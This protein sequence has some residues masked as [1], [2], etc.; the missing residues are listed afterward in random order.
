MLT[1]YYATL[2]TL[3]AAG[4]TITATGATGIAGTGGVYIFPAFFFNLPGQQ[5]RVRASGTLTTAASSPGTITW[6]VLLGGT[7]IITGAA[8]ATMTASQTTGLWEIDATITIRSIG[9]SGTCVG[10]GQF[11]ANAI[12]TAPTMAIQA[13]PA[14]AGFGSTALNTTTTATLDVQSNFSATGNT[15]ICQQ[16]QVDA[17]L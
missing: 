13:L 11:R 17:V 14:T 12:A 6:T 1:P 9:T 15:L 5:I 16:L 7:A 8:S 2:W 3:T 10:A 4:P